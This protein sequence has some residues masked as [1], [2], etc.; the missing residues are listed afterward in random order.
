MARKA[1]KS[2][3]ISRKVVRNFQCHY[4]P[5][6][7]RRAAMLNEPRVPCDD[8]LRSG[9][10]PP[11]EIN[12]ADLAGTFA[13]ILVLAAGEDLAFYENR[14]HLVA[15]IQRRLPEFAGIISGR[16]LTINTN[17]GRT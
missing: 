5:G 15:N 14:I 16:R 12:S 9:D 6:C 8:C 10:F 13:L 7:L 3:P 1:R 11:E 4:Y 2:P 17:H